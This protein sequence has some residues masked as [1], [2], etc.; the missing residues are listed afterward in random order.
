K[1]AKGTRGDR[2]ARGCESSNCRRGCPG[3]HLGPRRRRA[4]RLDAKVLGEAPVC[5]AIF[6]PG[7]R[8]RSRLRSR[9][10]LAKRSGWG[11]KH[12]FRRRRGTS[13]QTIT[14]GD[15]R[16]MITFRENGAMNILLASAWKFA[17]GCG[18]QKQSETEGS[19]SP[20]GAARIRSR[21][22]SIT[23]AELTSSATRT[24]PD[25]F[26]RKIDAPFVSPGVPRVSTVTSPV[27]SETRLGF[28]VT[29]TAKGS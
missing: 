28:T 1:M 8:D 19:H 26:L 9:S 5:R 15:E 14:P 24:F 11:R 20:L 2:T 3:G 6:V 18:E 13:D 29:P 4:A 12:F 21:N 25:G 22:R 7:E 16:G 10:R 27:A 23:A 17:D